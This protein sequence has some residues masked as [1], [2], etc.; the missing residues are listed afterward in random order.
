MW[1]S[2]LAALRG[3]LSKTCVDGLRLTAGVTEL[4]NLSFCFFKIVVNLVWFSTFKLCL[5]VKYASLN[6]E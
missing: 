6:I 4:L 3:E 2:L 1:C 5:H